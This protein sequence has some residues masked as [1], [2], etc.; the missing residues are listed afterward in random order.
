MTF[1]SWPMMP[2]FIYITISG[3]MF[4]VFKFLGILLDENLTWKYHLT[5]LSKKLARTRGMTTLYFH[6]FSI[7]NFS[8]GCYL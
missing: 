2:S 5:E 3:L 1:Q 6:L 8:L 4:V 7:L